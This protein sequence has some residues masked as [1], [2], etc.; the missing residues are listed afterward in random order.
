EVGHRDQQSLARS[1][2]RLRP[3][4][5]GYTIRYDQLTTNHP[6]STVQAGLNNNQAYERLIAEVIKLRKQLTQTRK[7]G[8]TRDKG[9]VAHVEHLDFLKN[10]E[11]IDRAIR[12]SDDLEQMLG[13]V[14]QVILSVFASDRAWLLYPCDPETPQW[15]IPMEATAPEY[16]GASSADAGIPTSDETAEVFRAALACN[17]PLMFGCKSG[18]DLPP[19]AVVYDVKSMLLIAVH[20]KVG[21]PW[22]FGLHQCSSARPWTMNEQ[23]LFKEISHRVAD[24]LSSMLFLKDL[25][26]S[27]EKYRTLFEQSADAIL[28]L[29]DSEFL[30]CNDAVVEMFRF[31]YK[32][33]LLGIHPSDLS[34]LVQSDGR[35]SYQKANEM[36]AI[37]LKKGSHR[38]E[39]D[40]RRADG[41]VFPAEILLTAIPVGDKRIL[42]AIVRDITGRKLAE[43]QL[44][45][46]QKMEAIGQ[47][48]GGVAHDFNNLL[49]C[50]MGNAQLLE[51]RIPEDSENSPLVRDIINASNR[52]A[53]LTGQLLSFSRKGR[54]QSINVD[55]HE[56]IAEVVRLLSHSID[57]RIEIDQEL[58][59]SQSIVHGDPTQ[60]QN[61]IL[62]LGVNARDAMPNGGKLT[63]AT[64][65]ITFDDGSEVAESYEVTGGT[66]LEI[67]VADTGVGMDAALQKR[68]FEPFFTTKKQ[69][70]GT[71]LG[72]AGVYGCVHSHGGAVQV[73]SKIAEGSTFKILLPLSQDSAASPT[74]A[75]PSQPVRGHGRILVVEDE[76]II[77]NFASKALGELGYQVDTCRNGATGVKFFE[78]HHDEIDLVILDLIMPELGGEDAFARMMEIDPDAHILISSGF[79]Q[80]KTTTSLLAAGAKGFLNKPFDVSELSQYV[81][82]YI[83]TTK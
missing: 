49:T 71:G 62:N 58:E 47:L 39:W 6:E 80:H 19:S 21:K 54:L 70:Q 15:R 76:E 33:Q 82:R 55:V 59:A 78:A 72:L 60:L 11:R 4:L 61:A 63:F 48:A 5:N 38:F 22:L 74:H 27:E 64:R 18:G 23:L 40:H 36:I 31:D 32:R 73:Y 52:A 35:N 9:D 56:I 57:R 44:R 12:R 34:P 42:H 8:K 26:D 50:I 77:R 17:A 79:S 46:S 13:D 43:E 37:A 1:T 2:E 3:R 14:L 53:D 45:Q 29:N 24:A 69:G 67:D 16:P 81:A 10:I 51:M 30:D 7:V 66:C 28:I 83:R 25:R 68:I 75:P 41:E 65:N 20:P